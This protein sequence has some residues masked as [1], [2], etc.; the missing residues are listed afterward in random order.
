MRKGIVMIP[1]ADI[2][3]DKVFSAPNCLKWTLP[4]SK[5]GVPISQFMKVLDYFGN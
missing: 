4:C 1:V 2:E 5:T 3:R